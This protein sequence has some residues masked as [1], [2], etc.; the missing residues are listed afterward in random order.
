VRSRCGV[1]DQGALGLITAA[2]VL[3][4]MPG[5]AGLSSGAIG[6]ILGTGSGPLDEATIVA[7]LR[8][9]L[10]VGAER[11]VDKTSRPNGFFENPRIHIPL[12]Q[13]LDT[14]ASTLRSVGLGH[15]VDQFELTMNRAAEAAAG[16]AV[17]VFWSA[18]QTMTWSDARGILQGNDTAATAFFRSRTEAELRTRFH[19]IVVAKM[20]ELGSVRI[21]ERLVEAYTA[22]SLTTKPVFDPTDY[23]T[24]RALGGLFT[25]LGEEEKRIREDPAAR[26]TELLR[27]VFGTKS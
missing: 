8:E 5:C 13:E 20:N 21:Y 18:I 1:A 25:I 4:A 11:T 27:R 10:H 17:D 2:F 12:P 9:A 7:G 14:A 6:D 15:H 24:T 23:V 26:T 16:E 22:L 19:P 3:L